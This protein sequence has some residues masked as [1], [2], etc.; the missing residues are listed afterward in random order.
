MTD[1]FNQRADHPWVAAYPDN[2]NWHSE[3]PSRPL[4]A[5]LD[6]AAERFGPNAFLDFLGKKYR[7]QEAAET[8][9]RLARGF[10]KHGVGKGTK[11]GLF[12]PNCPYF[13]LCYFAVLKAG[14]TVVTYNPL[15]AE[16]ELVRQIQ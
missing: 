12:L 6:D 15:L 10:R 11:V 3:I 9:G 14:G 4:F 1:E 7:Y 8:V 5:L 13:V 2:L 16:R